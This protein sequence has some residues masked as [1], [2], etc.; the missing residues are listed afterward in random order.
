MLN[1][2]YAWY[3]KPS[4]RLK[5]FVIWGPLSETVCSEVSCYVNIF[6]KG[7]IVSSEV[8]GEC[9]CINSGYLLYVSTTI[10]NMVWMGQLLQYV[11]LFQAE[12]RYSRVYDFIGFRL[13]W[14]NAHPSHIFMHRSKSL[15]IFGR[16]T[17]VDTICLEA[18][19][20]W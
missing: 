13:F 17:N 7:F 20:N 5:F 12:L 15:S 9:I 16:H 4:E 6:I 18:M 14:Y 10:Q 11:N 8:V 19:G 3:D 2:M 1:W